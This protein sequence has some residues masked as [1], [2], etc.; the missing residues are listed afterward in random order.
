[1]DKTLLEYFRCPEDFAQIEGNG[2]VSSD[3]GYF[4]FGQDICYGQYSGGL[5]SKYLVHGL[6][7]ASQAVRI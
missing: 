4:Q 1:M 3:P 2:A 5:T 6:P 7:D